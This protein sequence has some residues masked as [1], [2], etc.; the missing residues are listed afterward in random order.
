M[1]IYAVNVS[2][3]Q[4]RR[5]A[6]Q[7]QVEANSEDEAMR[8]AEDYVECGGSLSIE[9]QDDEGSPPYPHIDRS[10]AEA[11]DCKEVECSTTSR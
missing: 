1:S 2:A 4:I 11:T 6:G 7:V 3:I 8:K 5:V 10:T 9:W